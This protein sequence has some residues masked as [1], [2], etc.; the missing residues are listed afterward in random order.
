MD[1]EQTQLTA[2]ESS[3]THEE[4][5]LDAAALAF[6]QRKEPAQAEDTPD[7]A[8]AT[9]DDPNAEGDADS[10]EDTAEELEEIEIE[11][12][13][14]S[15]PKD[16]AEAVQKAALRQADYSRKMNEVA[17]KEKQAEQR[18][19]RAEMLATGIGKMADVKAQLTA[20]EHQVKQYEGINWQQL[21]ATDIGQY[22][23]LMAE[24][25]NLVSRKAQAEFS[26]Q[27]V[28][29][30]I[31]A[32]HVATFNESRSEMT[33]ALQKEFKD[34]AKSSDEICNFAFSKGVKQETLAKLTDPAMVVLLDKARKYDALQE[35]K[36]ALRAKVQDAPKVLKPGAPRPI[37]A[38]TDA[39]A[40]LRKSNSLDDA[41]AAFLSR[42]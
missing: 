37:N 41:A 5:S 33:K 23:A 29:D 31:S 20:I 8:E 12:V 13:K 28:E 24:M 32:A 34:W 15:V 35:S 39:M 26:V 9:D 19:E 3:D 36:V 16:K 21:R 38:K 18:L 14:F 17:A 25:N 4:G 1:Q 10:D 40:R 27:R 22:A 7:D 2:P 42:S 11:G 30:E 6:E